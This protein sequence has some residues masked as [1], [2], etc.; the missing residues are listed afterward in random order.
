LQCC[1][2]VGARLKRLVRFISYSASGCTPLKLLRARLLHD[3]KSGACARPVMVTLATREPSHFAIAMQTIR[4]LFSACWV[5][6]PMS[7]STRL[8]DEVRGSVEN[9]QV[10]LRRPRARLHLGQLRFHFRRRGFLLSRPASV[11][12]SHDVAIGMSSNSCFVHARL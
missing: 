6:V 7:H 9:L 8:P 12:R 1:S 10:N 5:L 4:E 2:R 11:S 3:Q